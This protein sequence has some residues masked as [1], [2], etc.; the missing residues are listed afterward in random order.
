VDGYELYV[1][2]SREGPL[3]SGIETWKA[4]RNA[5]FRVI[6]LPDA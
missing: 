4:E 5:Y 2:A 3:Q 1:V 6:R